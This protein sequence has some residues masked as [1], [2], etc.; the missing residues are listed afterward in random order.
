MIRNRSLYCNRLPDQATE[1]AEATQQE[2]LPTGYE[3]DFFKVRSGRVME[4][5]DDVIFLH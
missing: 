3:A 5:H 1:G 4:K 2:D